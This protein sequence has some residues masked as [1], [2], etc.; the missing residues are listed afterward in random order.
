MVRAF[1]TETSVSVSY[2]SNYESADQLKG[3]AIAK[4]LR[5]SWRTSAVDNVASEI[6][7]RSIAPQLLHSSCGP[8]VW[9]GLRDTARARTDSLREFQEA[10]RLSR[11]SARIHEQEICNIFARLLDAGIEPVL[12]KGWAI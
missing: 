1:A 7:L 3:D 8:L 5:G 12:V 6:E 2:F 9:W 4:L 10:Y 11:L